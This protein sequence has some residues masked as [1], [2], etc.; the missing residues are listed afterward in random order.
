MY[1]VVCKTKASL[2]ASDEYLRG[3]S[4]FRVILDI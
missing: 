1:D 2:F 3:D 4:S